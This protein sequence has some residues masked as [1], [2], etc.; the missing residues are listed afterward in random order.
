M[1]G[2]RDSEE[3]GQ[4]QREPTEPDGGEEEPWTQWSEEDWRLWNEGR[5]LGEGASPISAD[6]HEAMD[7][8]SNVTW[9]NGWGGNR[10]TSR[11]P[12]AASQWGDPWNGWNDPWANG[13]R[14][15]TTYEARAGGG[16]DKIIVPEFTGEDDKE[17]GKTKGYLRKVDAWRRVTRLPPQKQALILYNSL[18][19]KAWRDAE[20]L[21]V[22]TL[23]AEDG[24]ERFVTWIT[25]RYLDKEVIKAGRYMSDF[26]KTFKKT[27]EQDIRDY[28]MEFDRHMT[29]L[30]EIGCIL[31]G[32]CSSWW[33]VDKLRLDNSSEL[34]LL[35]S[36]GNQ[37]D[38]RKLQ[39]AAVVQD[40]MNRRIWENNKK[41]VRSDPRRGQQAL[42][43]ELEDIDEESEGLDDLELYSG[44]ETAEGDGETQEAFVAFQN[45]KARYREA[46]KARGTVGQGNREEALQKAKARSF[47]SACGRKGHWHRD[48][49]CPKN[50]E[51]NSN[52]PHTTHVVFFT[53]GNSMDVIADCAC[54]RT[55]AGS[56]WVKNYVNILKEHDI[57]YFVINQNEVFKFGGAKLYPSRQ[58]VVGWLR[59]DGAWFAV[60]ISVV[61]ADIPLLLSRPVLASLGMNFRMQ[62]NKADF[63]NLGLREV[64]LKFTE[65]GHP[66]VDAVSGFAGE[67]API[68]P[69]KVDWSVTE[70]HIPIFN[71]TS[72]SVRA[73]MADRLQGATPSLFYPKVGPSAQEFL[74]RDDFPHEL[75]LHW[76][77]RQ[78]LTKDFWIETEQY[79]I[80]IHV[81]PRRSFFDPSRWQTTNETLKQ[82][83][84]ERLGKT[85]QSTCIPC[86]GRA[87]P[88]EVEH[89]WH[90][91]VGP[92]TDF[93]W[94]GRSR[95]RRAPTDQARQNPIRDT[96]DA[97]QV[98]SVFAMED[99]PSRA[100][101]SPGRGQDR[102][103]RGVDSAGV[104]SHP[105]GELPGQA[106]QSTSDCRSDS[107]EAR[108]AEG[109]VHDRGHRGSREVHAW[110][111]DETPAGQ[112]G[113]NGR[114]EGVLRVLQGV[115]VQGGARGLPAVGH[116]RDQAEPQ[117]QPG[118][119]EVGEVG[120][121]PRSEGVQGGL[122]GRLWQWGSGGTTSRAATQGSTNS[123][124]S[125]EGA[126]EVAEED[127]S[128]EERG[129]VERLFPGGA[130]ARGG[131]RGPA[132]QSGWRC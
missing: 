23:D 100:D 68:W 73:Y 121:C 60:K 126:S 69:D 30:K 46:I 84:M 20:E 97:S 72:V 15:N 21:D 22:S 12:S 19:G 35:S 122:W 4:S 56:R 85:R 127:A 102:V 36:V 39:E 109:E 8:R 92:R 59:V 52:G 28:N 66:K 29:K 31:P 50:K 61:S 58:A 101:Q 33:Y 88:I 90:Q 82:Q 86:F 118:S 110:R 17:G 75:F 116:G 42:C 87:L 1:S 111:P 24:V 117:P 95:F 62:E 91:D 9:A 104:E 3:S 124:A 70:V 63:T 132:E 93:M 79:M 113:A 13:S 103:P 6:F 99:E 129:R 123:Q 71:K 5:W 10:T 105:T 49:D 47:C 14:A 120:S 57:P 98:L 74:C 77:T 108:R 7:E 83:L 37:Y 130:D 41:A 43:T 45:A 80:R 51:K 38:L 48:P 11:T 96:P 78:E 67:S 64:Q 131:D 81:T 2:T 107:P 115:H 128:E 125:V 112:Q 65:T 53:E 34:N 18:S 89:E 114:G 16:N 94:V 76:W 44:D 26:F 27:A 55:L 32:V 40:R 119:G 54:S 106:G 25:E